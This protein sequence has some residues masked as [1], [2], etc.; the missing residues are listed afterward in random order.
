[1]LRLV[2]NFTFSLP[3]IQSDA[4]VLACVSEESP[5]RCAKFVH[6]CQQATF[7]QTRTS[8]IGRRL[9]SILAS[10]FCEYLYN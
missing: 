10:E 2:V 5:N 6:L 4:S 7:R 3:C 8:D 1:M 9:T